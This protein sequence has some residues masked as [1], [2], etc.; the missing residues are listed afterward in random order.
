MTVRVTYWWMTVRVTKSNL[1]VDGVVEESQEDVGGLDP[2][3]SGVHVRLH[4]RDAVHAL[5]RHVAQVH[6]ASLVHAQIPQLL[7][8]LLNKT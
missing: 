5:S 6:E 7:L 8:V 2:P 3:A 1:L 4:A